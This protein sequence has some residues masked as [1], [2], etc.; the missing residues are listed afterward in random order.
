MA[1]TGDLAVPNAHTLS[2]EAIEAVT[3]FELRDLLKSDRSSFIPTEVHR[4]SAEFS[5]RL[6]G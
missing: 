1:D 5:S 3:D 2:A 6:R 4:I